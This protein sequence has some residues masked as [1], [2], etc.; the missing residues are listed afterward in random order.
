[1]TSNDEAITPSISARCQEAEKAQEEP[2]KKRGIEG[3]ETVLLS[4]F[5]PPI[6]SFPLPVA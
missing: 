5:S 4:L 2:K 6:N 3:T 1:M